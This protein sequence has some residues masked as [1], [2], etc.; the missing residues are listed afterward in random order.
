MDSRP[1]DSEASLEALLE[2]TER[3]GRAVRF[4]D[5][6]ELAR[7]YRLHSARLARLR[8]QKTDP[9][10]IRTLN[11]LC[12]RAYSLVYAAPRRRRRRGGFFLSELPATLAA[13]WRMQLLVALL[14]FGAAAVGGRLVAEDPRALTALVPAGM[15][16]PDAL[17]G[18]S[19]SHEARQS[20]LSP[21][22]QTLA[23][24]SLFSTQLFAHNTRVGLLGFAVGVLGGIPTVLL[25][26]Y[27]GLTLGAFT[28][29]F[30]ADPDAAVFWAWIIPHAIPELLAIVLCSTG[31]LLMGIA[32]L[33]PGRVGTARALRTAAR[34]ALQ[35]VIGALPLFLVAA[36]IESFV[37]Q[38]NL[39][40]P[41][42]FGVAV[43]ALASLAGYVAAVTLL[44]RRRPPVDVSFLS[45]GVRPLGSPDSD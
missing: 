1:G 3:L 15:Y 7:L 32:V 37:R 43:L 38:S 16:P 11:A 44:A 26:A 14:L 9:E 30:A 27:N 34:R 10:A 42:R 4:R 36:L 39:S 41:G 28:S 29:I 35:L 21:G 13:T 6:R 18:L 33:S 12:V 19:S 17:E 23:R 31:G 25:V 24:K 2:R 22:E 5:I 40:T 45:T 8:T 20:F